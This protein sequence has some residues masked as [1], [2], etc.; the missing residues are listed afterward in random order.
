MNRCFILD[1]SGC[2]CGDSI[3]DGGVPCIPALGGQSGSQFGS[4]LAGQVVGFLGS[5]GLLGAFAAS[6]GVGIVV[7]LLRG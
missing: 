1:D 3:P 2:I 6:V 4:G 5:S 7:R